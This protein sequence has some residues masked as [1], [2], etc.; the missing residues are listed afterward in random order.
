[1]KETVHKMQKFPPGLCHS[2]TEF[3]ILSVRLPM[4]LVQSVLFKILTSNIMVKE[5][6]Y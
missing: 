1:M 4:F 5:I 2:E 3:E 6:L